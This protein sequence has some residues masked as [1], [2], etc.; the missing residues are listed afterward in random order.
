MVSRRIRPPFHATPSVDA[1]SAAFD[2]TPNTPSS[3]IRKAHVRQERIDR[4]SETLISIGGWMP[5]ETLFSLCSRWHR[6]CSN[7][8]ASSTCLD[9]FG[10]PRIGS[11]QDFPARIACFDDRTGGALG[12]ARLIAA[13]RTHLRYYLPFHGE[14]VVRAAIDTVCGP[15]LGPLKMLLGLP[16][17]RL[18]ANHPLKSCSACRIED[19]KNHQVA[20]WHMAHQLPGAWRC[21]LHGYPLEVAAPKVNGS[22]RFQWALP[23]DQ[24]CGFVSPIDRRTLSEGQWQMLMRMSIDAHALS[25]VPAGYFADRHQLRSAFRNALSRADYV[26]RSGQL[27]VK[28]IGSAFERHLALVSSAPDFS[29]LRMNAD[30]ALNLLRKVMAERSEVKHPARVLAVIGLL[31]DDWCHFQDCFDRVTTSATGEPCICPPARFKTASDSRGHPAQER[32]YALVKDGATPSSAARAVGVDPHTGLAWLSKLGICAKGRP[33]KLV[34]ELRRSMVR[35]LRGGVEKALVAA[36]CE[37]SVETVTRVLRTTPGL[38]REWHEAREIRAR[39][40]ARRQ[41]SRLVEKFG[42]LGVKQ[43]RLRAP[44][45]FAWLYRNDK[46][47][48]SSVNGFLPRIRSGKST[49]VDWGGR[50]KVYAAA[51]GSLFSSKVA[52]APDSKVTLQ[53]ILAAVPELAPKLAQ[54]HLLPSTRSVLDALTAKRRRSEKKKE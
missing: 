19:R 7:G 12:P 44:D 15:K 32:F 13:E 20:Y 50:D 54:L 37:V 43:L 29:A 14:E 2:K 8:L 46:A 30:Q 53:E 40:H 4:I 1:P 47:W 33:K 48:L 16:A 5:D 31:F 23:D 39:K 24:E 27:K 22:R 25:V 21:H 42:H 49:R 3:E 9:L 34:G 35:A 51:I 6:V 28:L 36:R 52:A 41:W 45:A 18:R 17:A 26:G 10:H 11:A 38:Q